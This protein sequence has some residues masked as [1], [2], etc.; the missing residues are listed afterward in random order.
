MATLNLKNTV[1]GF[2]FLAA[3]LALGACEPMTDAELE[4][5]QQRQAQLQA[6][7]SRQAA[8]RARFCEDNI[9]CEETQQLVARQC[10]ARIRQ[11]HEYSRSDRYGNTIF[12]ELLSPPTVY[13]ER[14][15]LHYAGFG[16]NDRFQMHFNVRTNSVGSPNRMSFVRYKASC[17]VR[18]NTTQIINVDY[19]IL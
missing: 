2:V 13:F 7:R 10:E 5:H 12:S 6:Q 8:E 15:P 11:R 16:D 18:K 1:A 17:I 3:L 4:I 19:D 9:S 14:G